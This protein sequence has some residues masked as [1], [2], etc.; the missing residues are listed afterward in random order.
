MQTARCHHTSVFCGELFIISGPNTR[1][2][3]AYTPLKASF[4]GR[5]IQAVPTKVPFAVGAEKKTNRLYYGI[6]FKREEYN[7]FFKNETK[8]SWE[9]QFSMMGRRLK[10]A[11][12]II[13]IHI[14]RHQLS[15][16]FMVHKREV[17][18]GLI[19]MQY[20]IKRKVTI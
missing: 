2:T 13:V 1:E 19:I 18:K 8:F 10:E 16:L 5:W 17:E 20:T 4:T 6:D 11:W 14:G 3:V 7:K 15:L 12:R 9:K